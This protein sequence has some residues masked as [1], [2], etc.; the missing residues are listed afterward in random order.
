ML[1]VVP[2][3]E[4]RARRLRHRAVYLLVVDGDRLL[5]HRRAEH[6][7]LWPGRW[8][9][10]AGGVVAAGEDWDDAA[11]RELREELGI[12]AEP[13][14]VADGAWDGEEC[15]VLGR[16]YVVEHPGPFTFDD[17]EVVEARFVTP[18]EL[19]RM[20]ASE[21]FCPDSLALTR[22]GTSR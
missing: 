20:L 18:E 11:R 4:M 3:A 22:R 21:A 7:D 12:D 19:E 1:G 15:K 17:G 2:R 5:V 8:D 13:R 16:V 14:H 9:V 10:A 6:K